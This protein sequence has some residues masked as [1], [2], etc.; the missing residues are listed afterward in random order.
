ME[1]SLLLSSLNPS[2]RPNC[3]KAII[4]SR[5]AIEPYFYLFII[6]APSKP[7]KENPKSSSINSRL[8]FVLNNII[9]MEEAKLIVANLGNFSFTEYC[10]SGSVEYALA[11]TIAL[12]TLCFILTKVTSEMSWVD[13]IWSLLPILYQAHYIYHQ[14]NC[15]GIEI[16]NRQWLIFFFT[17]AWGIRLTFNFFRKGGYKAGGEDYRW[18]YVR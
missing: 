12:G 14:S 2:Y 6:N 9:K 1:Y 13:R 3:P 18:A 11:F 17:S 7:I 16:S 15:R 5:P 8:F 10:E 4:L